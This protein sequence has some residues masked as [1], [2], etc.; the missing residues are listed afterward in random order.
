MGRK[1]TYTQE[2]QDNAVKRVVA[3]GNSVIVVARQLGLQAA[4]LRSWV[5]KYKREVKVAKENSQESYIQE[6]RDL[7]KENEELREANEI[8]KKAAAYFA[9]NL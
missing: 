3:D 9:K 6:L 1:S 2:Y 4:M 5:Q 8:L 7:R